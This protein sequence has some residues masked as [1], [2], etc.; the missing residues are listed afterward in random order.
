MHSHKALERFEE[1]YRLAILRYKE[2]L[3]NY[4]TVLTVEGQ[5]LAQRR[6]VA[7]LEAERRTNAVGLVRAL[8]GGFTPTP[9]NTN[10][11]VPAA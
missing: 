9:P 6:Q 8:G 7:D 2:G 1:A 4:L 5:V 11:T 3:T 10:D